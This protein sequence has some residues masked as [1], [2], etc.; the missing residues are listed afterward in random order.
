MENNMKPP[1]IDIDPIYLDIFKE[2]T[3]DKM[4]RKEIMITEEQEEFAKARASEKHKG[5]VSAWIRSLI[6]KE[7][8]RR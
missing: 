4:K 3:G 6:E 7:I 8:N 2:C 1:K 5:N